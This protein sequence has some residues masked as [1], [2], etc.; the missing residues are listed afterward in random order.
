LERLLHLLYS[1]LGTFLY[2]ILLLF[3]PLVRLSGGRYGYG[4]EQRLGWYAKSIGKA[5]PGSRTVWL[6]ASSVGE[7]QAAIVLITELLRTGEGLRIILTS[8]TEQGNRLARSRLP[9]KVGCLMAPLDVPQAV[10]QALRVVRPDLY[11]CLETELWPVML[12]TLRKTGVPLLLLNGRL[13]ERSYKRYQWIRPLVRT[14]LEGF[15]AVA[16]ISE[17]D[18]ARFVGLGVPEHRMQVCGNLK[19]DLP[20]EHPE[21]LRTATRRRLGVIDQKVLLCGSTHEG[22][23]ALLL[24]V[25]RQ[26]AAT[27]PLVWVVAPRHLERLPEVEA[28][29]RR[30]GL[31]FDR[32]SQLATQSRLA[33]VVLVDT[34]GDLA[35]LYAGGDF[36]FCGGSLVEKGGHNIMEAAR[37]GRPVYFGPSMNDFLDAAELLTAAGGGFQV[38]DAGTLTTLLL[39][40]HTH[41][42]AYQAACTRAATLATQQRGAVDRQA[43]IVRQFLAAM[44]KA[45]GSP[46][47]LS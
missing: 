31:V 42:E 18:G 39:H 29:F 23:E 35:D 33:S 37:W 44:E 30:S 5:A 20:A 38:A 24:P 47:F 41:P 1:G 13:S 43:G 4:L 10:R 14:L 25:F 28:F 3:L 40:H 36:I 34:M 7:V 11:I 46:P 32:Y 45:V 19:Y 6:H 22:E 8:T 15:Q 26:L 12:L 9:E 27:F 16:V 21:Q 17:A 2:L